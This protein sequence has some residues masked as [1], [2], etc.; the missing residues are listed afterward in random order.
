MKHKILRFDDIETHMYRHKDYYSVKTY[1]IASYLQ[2]LDAS[3][4]DL[5]ALQENETLEHAVQRYYGNLELWDMTIALNSFSPLFDMPKGYD[6]LMT[7]VEDKINNYIEKVSKVNYVSDD[8]RKTIFDELFYEFE[9][10]NDE[11]RKIAFIKNQ[12]VEQ[13][14]RDMRMKGLIE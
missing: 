11:K 3:Y 1:K 2:S 6:D 8:M 10:D 14:I 4:A 13:V 9:R 12:F 5:V 7:K